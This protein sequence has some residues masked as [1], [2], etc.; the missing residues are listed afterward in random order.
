MTAAAVR[1][2]ALPPARDGFYRDIA[3]LAYPLRQGAALPGVVHVLEMTRSQDNLTSS[4][5][6]WHSMP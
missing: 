3:V 1:R 6:I 5:Q 4:L 2:F